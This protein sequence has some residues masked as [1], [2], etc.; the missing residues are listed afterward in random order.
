[1][2]WH[3]GQWKDGQGSLCA[4][5]FDADGEATGYR[6]GF[7]RI[8]EFYPKAAQC[9]CRLGDLLML[10][11]SMFVFKYPSL[12]QFLPDINRAAE[13]HLSMI[14]RLLGQW[15]QQPLWGEATSGG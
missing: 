8:E 2:L 12:Y 4:V 6:S 1:M 7:E 15:L 11:L 5:W 3:G 10:A 14:F 13:G 9:Q